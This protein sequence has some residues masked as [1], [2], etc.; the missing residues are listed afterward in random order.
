[1]AEVLLPYA[2]PLERLALPSA[3]GPQPPEGTGSATSSCSNSHVAV[4]IARIRP[5]LW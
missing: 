4:E 2:K 3:E 5:A 1:M